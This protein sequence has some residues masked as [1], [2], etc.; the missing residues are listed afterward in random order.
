M[1]MYMYTEK[2]VKIIP[3]CYWFFSYCIVY[4]TMLNLKIPIVLISDQFLSLST[5]LPDNYNLYGLGEHVTPFLRLQP[6]TYTLWTFDTATTQYLNL[7]M[8]N[9][10]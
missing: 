8:Y 1:Y 10:V 4:Y 7:C 5:S 3:V 9:F 6:H 2:F